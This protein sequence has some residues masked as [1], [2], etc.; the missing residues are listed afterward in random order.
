MNLH[1]DYSLSPKFV[2]FHTVDKLMTGLLISL[3]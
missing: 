3:M 2:A 1:I